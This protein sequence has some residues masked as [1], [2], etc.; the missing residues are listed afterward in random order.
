M[1]NNIIKDLKR[2]E[3]AK[4]ESS[5]WHSHWEDLARVMHTRRVGFI[6]EQTDG[7][8]RNEDI[9]DGTP[10]Q[11][12]RGLANAVGGMMRPEGEQ[13]V[14]MRASDDAIDN[15]D[16]A[17]EWFAST[18]KKM[19]AA[20]DNPKSR[21]RQATGEADLD[22]VVF[23]TSALTAVEAP[24]QDHI[25]LQTHHLRDVSFEFNDAGELRAA[26][27]SKKHTISQ[28]MEMFDLDN[29][30]EET[31]KKA[32]EGKFEDKI[33]VLQM[34]EPRKMG[35]ADALLSL[36]FPYA[37]KW[38][39]VDSKHL[40]SEGGFRDMPYIVPMWD[41]SS[42]EKYGRSPGMIA[43]PDANT[44][45]A[46]GET[47]LVAGQRVASPPLLVPNDGMFSEVNAFPDGI[48]YYDVETA[49]QMGRNPI[50]PLESGGNLPLTRDMQKDYREQIFTAF[51]RNV[52][53]LPI[54]GPQMT[55]TEVI[56]RKEEFI[57]EIGPVF[58]RLETTYTAPLVERVFNIMLRADQFDPI[59]EV[60]QGRSIR[61]E[62]ESPVKKIREQTQAAAM[63]LWLSEVAELGQVKPEALDLINVDNVVKFSA[64][65]A[66][67]PQGVVNGTDT[68]AEIRNGRQ[69]Q[70]EQEQQQQQLQGVLDGAGQAVDVAQKLQQ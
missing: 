66:N 22:L 39:E 49:I 68:V 34:I 24:S 42:G 48:S 8:R 12:A 2:W 56:Q 47:M 41:T 67:L 7:E 53:N 40:I 60:L 69:Q 63:R 32:A 4:Q 15:A 5:M 70:M 20:L 44:L 51:Y 14:Q 33:T 37:N 64:E 65:A 3:K 17:K 23:G 6:T 38:I 29:L 52:L 16:E 61:F 50:F 27:R 31:R 57:R 62:Y 46:M 11:A 58:G 25:L 35:D 30:S 18:E 10:M 55:A 21:Y 1:S 59:P 26:F 45:Q 28:A 36:R 43:L 54:T 13:W 9:F 19:F